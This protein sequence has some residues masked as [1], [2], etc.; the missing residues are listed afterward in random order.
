MSGTGFNKRPET[1]NQITLSGIT[2]NRGGIVKGDLGK[3]CRWGEGKKETRDQRPDNMVEAGLPILD[4]GLIR[5][6]KPETG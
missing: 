5:D 6:Q 4:I 3:L 1:G 2:P